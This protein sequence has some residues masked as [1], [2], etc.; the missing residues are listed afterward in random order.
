MLCC[1]IHFKDTLMLSCYKTNR[2]QERGPPILISFSR[3][4]CLFQPEAVPPHLP[5]VLR[6]LSMPPS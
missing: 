2:P 6:T 4:C 1:L 3:E 5:F